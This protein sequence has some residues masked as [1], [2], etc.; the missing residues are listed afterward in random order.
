VNVTNRKHVIMKFSPSL[1]YCKWL[2][3][4]ITILLYTYIAYLVSC[5]LS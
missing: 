1:L 4:R 2:C 3:E 5:I